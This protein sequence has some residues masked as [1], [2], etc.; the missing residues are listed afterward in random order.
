MFAFYD[1]QEL[2][3]CYAEMVLCKLGPGQLGPWAQ[4]SRA[5]L[6]APKKWQIGPCT[7][8]ARGL[9]VREPTVSHEKVANWAPDSAS[10]VSHRCTP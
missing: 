1:S 9:V 4:L 7:V 3:D 10:L 5:Q 2:L 6:S 8:W